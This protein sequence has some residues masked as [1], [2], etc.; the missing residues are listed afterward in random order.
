MT[1]QIQIAG[2]QYT[3]RQFALIDT[4]G[5]YHTTDK[6]TVKVYA[7]RAHSDKNIVDWNKSGNVT[8]VHFGGAYS[9]LSTEDIEA[10]SQPTGF[11]GLLKELE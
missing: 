8:T 1:P 7:L 9:P 11:T 6:P 5:R 3:P 10:L 4:D 2:I